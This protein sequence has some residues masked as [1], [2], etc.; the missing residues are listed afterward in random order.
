VR[1]GARFWDGSAVT[2]RSILEGWSVNG[3]QPARRMLRFANLTAQGDRELRVELISAIKQP[4]LFAQPELAVAGVSVQ[5]GWP[6]GTGPFR[7]DAKA[8]RGTI[9]LVSGDSTASR[10]ALEFR[11]TAD[12][13]AA[14]DARADVLLTADPA[15]LGYARILNDF[16]ITPLPWS[17]TYVLI[18]RDFVSGVA[19]ARAAADSLIALALDVIRAD[20]RR[21]QSPFW[22]EDEACDQE[23]VLTRG[24]PA[25]FEATHLIVYPAGDPVAQAIAERLVAL[26]WPLGRTPPWL[27]AL[28]PRETGRGGAPTAH[29]TTRI[30]WDAARTSNGLIVELP[31]TESAECLAYHFAGEN[32]SLLGATGIRIIPMVDA[33]DHLLIRRGA[34]PV[35]L[36]G[37]GTLRFG[38]VAR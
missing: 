38:S 12:G 35:V 11:T 30:R 33:R 1:E 9:R 16:L 7:P 31:R 10:L 22:W 36:D 13:R 19:N 21:A 25:L 26:S 2:A 32:R 29:G 5:A 17:R 3:S 23:T 24:P 28:L 15:A 37:D 4:Y 27:Q 8:E 6:P 14:L 18:T 20:V 34:G